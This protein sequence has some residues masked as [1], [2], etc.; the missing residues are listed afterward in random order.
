MPVTIEPRGDLALVVIDNPPVNAT[1]KAVRAG[2][3][4]AAEKVDA[5]P[6]VRGAVL[7]C[8]GR[9]FVAGGDV[10][11]FDG[12]P[13]PPHLPDVV[14]R[15]EAAAKPWL[16]AM[17]G[18]AFGGGL[19]LALGCRW[20]IAAKGTRLGLP[21]V[22]LG[23]I[24]GAGGTIRLPRLVPLEL[25][26]RMASQGQPITAALAREAGLLDAVVGGELE[27]EALTY[28]A[29]ALTAPLPPRTLNRPAPA[30]A[31]QQ[32]WAAQRA[33]ADK[34]LRGQTAPGFALQS[35]RNALG[36]PA[37]EALAQ[38]RQIHLNLRKAPES[39]AL[40]HVFFA[41]R[42]A[43]KA[44]VDAKPGPLE[45][46]GVVGGG[47][48][49][50][51]IAVAFL[52]AGL[53]V[54]LLER[55]QAS[56][57]RGLAAVARILD[58][59]VK[60]GR[61]SQ[62]DRDARWGRL[63]GSL[64][65]AALGTADV[66][67]E[68][69][70]ESLEVKREVFGRLDAACKPGAVLATNTSYIDP[71]AIAAATSRPDAVVGLHFFSPANVMKLLEVVRTDTVS[72]Q[73]LATAWALA[74]K[75]GKTPVLAGVCDGFIGN[76]ILKVFR[77]EAER[78]LLSGAHPGDVDH[79]M[80]A[81]GLPMGPFEA[82]DLAGLDI[83]AAM[84]AASRER[85]ETVFAPVADRLVAAGRLGQKAGCGW[86]DYEA[87]DRTPR[88]SDEVAEIIADEA[89][90]AGAERKDLSTETIQRL[91]L[92]PMVA[93]GRQIVAEGIAASPAAVDLVEILGFGF[94]RWR[95][96]LMHWGEAAGL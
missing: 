38:E 68:A 17:H 89:A 36:M 24:P 74:R 9:T 8:R 82:Q 15:I 26:A 88:P 87:G 43:L 62:A 10:S 78:L 4:E 91:I 75:L 27:A 42:A 48:M 2:L 86:Y 66:V 94:P 30:V 40:R 50:A 77:R 72:D 92:G 84:R 33:A 31:D 55:D 49:G 64:D 69:V 14:A 73:T 45:A 79:A 41:E 44:P 16:A 22:T 95:G 67:V 32:F 5:D 25:A 51:G 80:R 21:E 37:P 57:D 18:T 71:N 52:D 61:L 11:E 29:A 23:L 12:E 70:F 39:K 53:P 83:A 65:T 60:R 13:Q 1:S 90:K 7:L 59:A 34:K 56:L 54:T 35:L 20:R 46:A 58:G 81:F 3:M 85:G 28:L 6:A 47:T 96:G 76:R 63:A 19:E 93:E